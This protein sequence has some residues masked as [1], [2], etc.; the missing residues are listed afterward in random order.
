[1]RSNNVQHLISHA[2]PKNPNG[3]SSAIHQYYPNWQRD[4]KN[5]R[6]AN[7]E[8]TNLHP[9]RQCLRL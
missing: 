6:R 1:M 7:G 8:T 9:E 3:L 2:G 5:D 4:V